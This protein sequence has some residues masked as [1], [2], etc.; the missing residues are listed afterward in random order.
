L[1]T[2]LLDA[3]D[4]LAGENCRLLE[5]ELPGEGGPILLADACGHPVV[6]SFDPRNAQAA[7]VNGLQAVDRLTVA[8]PWIQRTYG[9]LD[10]QQRRPRLVVVSTELPP[11]GESVLAGAPGLS[12]FRC[13]LLRVNDE[14]GILLEPVTT[15]HAPAEPHTPPVPVPP[16][17]PGQAIVHSIAARDEMPPLSEQE[18]A[19]FQQL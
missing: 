9:G 15:D 1:R 8:L 17:A 12:L 7:L 18:L 5:P 2:L 13:R 4:Q 16:P 19:Y 6:L 3:A 14:T 11:G 10:R